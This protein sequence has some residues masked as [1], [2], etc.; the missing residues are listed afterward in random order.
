MNWQDHASCRGADINIFFEQK[1][2]GPYAYKAARSYCANCTVMQ[3]C[4][5]FIM[6]IEQDPAV[7]RFG[8]YAG[9]TPSQRENY[10][11]HLNRVRTA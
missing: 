2:G 9:M 7:P 10:Q 8:M 3:Q 1:G 5:E 6:E 11:D 4:F